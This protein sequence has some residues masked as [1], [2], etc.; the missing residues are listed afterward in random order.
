MIANYS[1]LMSVYNK[2]KPLFLRQAMDSM[3]NQTMPTDD[4]VLVC[5]GRLTSELDK[6]IEEM[7]QLHS[8]T[9]H[10][11]RLSKNGGLGNALNIGMQHCRHELIARMDSDDISQ[12]YRCEKQLKLFE[13]KPEISIC[14]GMIEEFFETPKD[15]IARRVL[16]EYHAD[17]LRYAKTRNP[18]NHMA[19]MYRKSAVEKAGG[20][21]A[22]YLLEDYYLWIRMLL[23]GAEGYNFQ[24]PLTW[25]R[26]GMDMYKRRGGWNYAVSQ[27]RLFNYMRK[28]GMIS[29]VACME[30]CFVRGA[31]AI[32]PNWIR[33]LLYENML[34]R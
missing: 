8:K 6:V 24:M 2:E 11:V 27:F 22:F 13:S 16:P 14:S 20:Y 21:Q 3:W 17:I 10:I 34:R 19:V 9:L 25:V 33:R 5:D 31:F 32:V 7:K 4:F 29:N 28:H 26:T 1:V 15:I 12:P 23:N 30:S 18:F